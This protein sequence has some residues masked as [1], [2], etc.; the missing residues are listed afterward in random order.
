MSEKVLVDKSNLVTIADK[1]R[2]VNGTNGEM[3]I[4][5]MIAGVSN[6]GSGES[7]EILETCT[8]VLTALKNYNLIFE[9]LEN[10]ERKLYQFYS[11]VNINSTTTQQ[12]NIPLNSVLKGTSLLCGIST[13]A[14]KAVSISI[15]GDIIISDGN[16]S[17]QEG[18]SVGKVFQI[19]GDGSIII[20]E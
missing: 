6:L 1:V 15:A 19:N 17:T 9:Y 4:D 5:E 11:P 8:V 10:G 16:N 13:V 3:T 7:S 12:L 20:E 14:S 2:E 18:F